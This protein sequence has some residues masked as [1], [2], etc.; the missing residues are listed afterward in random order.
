MENK[1]KRTL[2]NYWRFI[3]RPRTASPKQGFWRWF[4]QIVFSGMIFSVLLF[5]V[6][7]FYVF[8]SI[9]S[10][11]SFLF[12][13]LILSL[14]TDGLF[15]CLH[16]L[17][18]PITPRKLKLDPKKVSAVIA[19][20]NGAAEIGKTIE[21][22]LRQL[23]PNQIIVVSDASTDDT[24]KVA[25]SYGV[26]V[27]VNKD[28]MNKAFSVS[29]GV[30]AVKTPYVLILD[31]DVLIGNAVIPSNL[32]DEGYS[33]V[34]FNVMPI[35]TDTFVNVLQQFEYRNS[36]YIGK[37]VRA[38]SGAIGNISGAIGLYRTEDLKEQAYLHSG[39][40]AGEDEQRTILTHIYGEGKGIAFSPQTVYTHAPN[41]FHAL[42]RQRA[43]SWS[44]AVPELLVLY[45]RILFSSR[46]HFLLK[47]EK[48]YY[49][50]IYLT[51]PLRML[52]LW[53]LLLRPRYFLLT[54][55]LYFIMNTLVWF[56]TGRK[57][58]F[59]TVIVYPVYTLWLS[60]CR[61]IGNFYWL[62]VKAR[63]FRKR[64]HKL[65]QRRRI[66]AEFTIVLALFL[67]SWFISTYHFA[68]DLRL[69][70]KIRLSRLEEETQTFQYDS[71]SPQK[72]TSVDALNLTF[73]SIAPAPG[74]YISVDVEKGDTLRAVAHKAVDRYLASHLEIRVPYAQR[75]TVDR[76]VLDAL[77]SDQVYFSSTTSTLMINNTAMQTAF[78]QWQGA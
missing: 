78:S 39:Q 13:F 77:K 59:L 58:Q 61:F 56:K 33:A 32:L 3:N 25:H 52:F 10:L 65:V 20:Y 63:Y 69:F 68:N 4:L 74:T 1:S 60:V 26:K 29:I 51:D 42:Y 38:G 37:N 2:R 28:N 62:I 54:Y 48:A 14:L 19:C 71:D 57:D 27:V 16:L 40:F 31:D 46:H 36:M 35:K 24:E 17:R 8:A 15:L 55:G 12:V 30:H 47:A 23:P 18:K 53:T 49:I 45:L 72:I 11:D 5:I 6:I 21:H 70:N 41:T 75:A 43:Y 67:S 7:N 9:V 66:I 50:Y 44:L 64:F 76:L 73:T 34:A 22:L